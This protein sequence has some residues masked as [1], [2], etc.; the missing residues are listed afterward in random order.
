[1]IRINLIPPEIL[2]NRKDETRWKWLWLGGGVLALVLAMFWGIMFLQV[3]TSTADVASVQQ[4]AATLQ[5]QS[6]RFRVFQQQEADLRTRQAAVAAAMRG[7]ID[8]ARLLNELG[9]VLPTDVYLTNLTGVD[10]STGGASGDSV[11]TLAGQAVDEPD[12]VPENGYKSVAKM[13]VRLADLQQLDSVWLTNTFTGGGSPTE[14]PMIT[15]AVNAR[16][17]PSSPSSSEN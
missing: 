1:M 7:R 17:T 3:I 10:N 16:I 15:W 2:Q 4:Q 8:W 14:A 11:V 12:D 5:A 6:S 13:L 9:L